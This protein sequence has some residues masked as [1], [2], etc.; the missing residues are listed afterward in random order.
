MKHKFEAQ[1]GRLYA[2]QPQALDLM[3]EIMRDRSNKVVD[4]VCIVSIQGPL[5]QHPSGPFDNYDD[6][7]ERFEEAME[8]ENSTAVVLMFDSPGGDAYGMIEARRKIQRL[9]KENP[10][11]PVY[12][13]SNECCFSAAYGLASACQEIWLP[14]TGGVGSVG[15]VRPTKDESAAYAKAGVRMLYI[16]APAGKAL[17]RPGLP[18]DEKT[19]ARIQAEVD[20]FADLF[21][22]G[23][24]R[25]RGISVEDILALQADTYHGKKAIKAGLADGISGPADFLSMIR[26]AH[27]MAA[28]QDSGSPITRQSS[29]SK[30]EPDMKAKK[31]AATLLALKAEKSTCLAALAGS[32]SVDERKTLAA[33]LDAVIGKLEAAYKKTKKVEETE[34]ETAEEEEE[35]ERCDDD[36]EAPADEEDDDDD[37]DDDDEDSSVSTGS[38]VDEKHEKAFLKA[39]S[40]LQTPARL[41]RLCKQITGKQDIGEVF[42]ALDAMGIRL[43]SAAKTEKRVAKLEESN[44]RTKVSALLTKAKEDGRVTPAQVPALK[45][46]GMKDYKWLKGYLSTL[47]PKVNQEEVEYDLSASGQA[48]SL[49]EQVSALGGRSN[50]PMSDQ[51]KILSAFSNGLGEDATKTFKGIQT[52]ALE[53]ANGIFNG[54]KSGPRF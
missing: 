11:K 13:Y 33:Q 42:G 43:K 40:G 4:G 20:Q 34:E 16:S 6:I 48:P 23:V 17:G 26:T 51:Q 12:A 45:E 18:V 31:L 7:L 10:N 25:S 30:Q 19:E 28:P 38:S 21:F 8:D 24:S 46:Q 52:A 54:T 35:E 5:D 22:K 29:S 50:V 41:L 39:T 53:K 36:D 37:D 2:A 1:A 15:V 14:S 32:K 47:A 3:Y 27:P 49:A 44:V 9:R